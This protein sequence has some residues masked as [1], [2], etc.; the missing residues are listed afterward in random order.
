VIAVQ[1]ERGLA[2]T[3]EL[4]HEAGA[5]VLAGSSLKAALDLDW[6]DPGACDAALAVVLTALDAVEAFAARQDLLGTATQVVALAPLHTHPHRLTFQQLNL[7]HESL[8][9]GVPAGREANRWPRPT[10]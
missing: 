7:P 10:A 1:Q 5:P 8:A 6:D 3:G 4:A 2:A 9:E